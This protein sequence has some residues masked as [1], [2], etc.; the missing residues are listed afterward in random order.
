MH[1]TT[2]VYYSLP[3][4]HT[5]TCMH[6]VPS[7]FP[8]N[9]RVNETSKSSRNATILWDN[10]PHI[11][12]NGEIVEYTLSYGPVNSELI[13]VTIS[14][15]DQGGMFFDATSLIPGTVYS[16]NIAASTSQGRGDHSNNINP[17]TKEESAYTIY[18][19]C[20]GAFIA[21]L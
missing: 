13:I 19:K 15:A 10:V 9:L 12:R 8:A 16:I 4:V 18:T 11:H 5:C 17:I 1:D 2:S 14:A 7:S 3:P 6:A 21:K 20:V